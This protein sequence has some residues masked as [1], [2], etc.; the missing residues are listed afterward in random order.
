MKP[1]R[2][3]KVLLETLRINMVFR[4]PL[5]QSH[6]GYGEKKLPGNEAFPQQAAGYQELE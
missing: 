3:S 4:R 2:D 5:R 6:D 1:I